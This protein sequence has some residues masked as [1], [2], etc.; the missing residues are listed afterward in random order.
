MLPNKM[1]FSFNLLP[2]KPWVIEIIRNIFFYA[3]YF[4]DITELSLTF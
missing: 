2:I 1:Y 4:R 3:T